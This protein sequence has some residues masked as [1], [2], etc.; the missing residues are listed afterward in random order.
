MSDSKTNERATF[1]NRRAFMVAAIGSAVG[2]GNIWRFPYIAFEN[3]G[4]AFLLPYLVALL[5]A[6]IPLLLLD[7]AI[8]HRYRGSPPLAFRRLGRWFE[9]V[10]WWNVMANIIICIYYA[11][12][13]GW[14][15]SYAYY[16]LNAAWGADPQAFFFKD[17]LNMA[18]PEALGLDFV[19]KVVGPLIG[20]W[21]FTCIIMALGVQKGVA[22]ASSFFMPLLLI[23]FI[24]MVGI[25]LTL[26]GAAKGLD[27]LFTPD[28]SKLSDPKV[29][30][31]AYGQIFF[32][33]SICFGIMVTYSSYLKK[34]TDL[35][36]T[37][38]VV[39]FANSS[40]ELLAGIGVFA[41]LGF[42][43]QAK[44]QAVSEVASS[45]IGLAFIAFP[46]IINQAGTMGAII[47][48]LFFG[49]LVFAGITSMISIVEVIVAAIQDK[50]NIGRVNAT[51]LVCIPM[52]IISTL[53]FGTTTGLPVLDVLDKFVNTYGIVAAG[54]VYVLAIIV[55]RK[56]PELRNHLNALSSVR[57]GAIWTACVI[58]TVAMLSYMLYQD[59]SG[60]L[61][62]NYSK[63]PD[64]FLN[65]F[66][67]GMSIGLIVIAVLLS[68][69]P[70][71]HGQNFNVKDEHEHE[72]GDKE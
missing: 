50:L 3:G 14:S 45:G 67:W 41:A 37:G 53:L 55:L 29:W 51:L 56:L 47:G 16:S 35:G 32:S 62:E 52:G 46:T 40:F 21:L 6:G 30:V 19:G 61:K 33:L 70:W 69:L 11:V 20:V 5:T 66:G 57:V 31:A 72:Q 8:G 2:L 7:Y 60:L 71:K 13:I 68:L 43:A 23:M 34:K 58:F 4:G 49:S 28:W 15:A 17:F 64:D 25:S 65:I 36:G 9:P 24:I 27:A 39:G 42:M 59:T 63:Y 1:N 44:G 54:F 38:L 22:G 18:G 12:I 10:G 48:I 26:P